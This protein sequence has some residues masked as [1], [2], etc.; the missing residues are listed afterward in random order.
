MQ[1]FNLNATAVTY[2]I[3]CCLITDE[4]L[5]QYSTITDINGHEWMVEDIAGDNQYYLTTLH[6]DKDYTFQR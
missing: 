6:G 3:L 2:K 1:V 4:H 5:I